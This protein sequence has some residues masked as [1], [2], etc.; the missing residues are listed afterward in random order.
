MMY[1]HQNMNMFYHSLHESHHENIFKQINHH[2]D[3][4]KVICTFYSMPYAN[5]ITVHCSPLFGPSIFDAGQDDLER[6]EA[7]AETKLPKRR[8]KMKRS[9]YDF[10]I[11]SI[12]FHH[13]P[14]CSTIFSLIF[15][16]FRN[17]TAGGLRKG[18]AA[19]RLAAAA[20]RGWR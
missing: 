16:Y 14:Y 8:L 9:S 5:Y 17:G 15:P 4:G 10:P 11:F 20:W 6:A 7:E 18:S 1:H 19:G 2:Q 13:V 3:I 12:C